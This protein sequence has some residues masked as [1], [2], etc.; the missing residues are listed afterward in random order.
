LLFPLELFGISLMR[1]LL[2]TVAALLP[3]TNWTTLLCASTIYC[4]TYFVLTTF[5]ILDTETIRSALLTM[6][7]SWQGGV[8]DEWL[9][10]ISRRQNRSRKAQ[11]LALW[12][13][14]IL[15][16]AFLLFWSLYLV[17]VFTSL[18]ASLVPASV[19]TPEAMLKVVTIF[20][21][22][23]ALYVPVV[24]YYVGR[25]S[26]DPAKLALISYPLIAAFRLIIGLLVV[27][28]IHR[29]WASTARSRLHRP[30]AG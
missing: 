14:I 24:V 18:Q 13:R 7:P 23:A 17:L 12:R 8:V 15:A 3:F 27:R 2:E 22:Q 1:S 25:S 11:R 29:F 16:L 10:N 20:V 28:R 9:H 21:E 26:L 6:R 30:E 4:I 19:A 5:L